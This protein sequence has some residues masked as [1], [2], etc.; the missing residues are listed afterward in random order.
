MLKRRAQ[1]TTAPYPVIGPEE[2]QTPPPIPA[3]IQPVSREEKQFIFQPPLVLRNDD[4]PGV[5]LRLVDASLDTPVAGQ[6]FIGHFRI[7]NL[8]ATYQTPG[9]VTA[10]GFGVFIYRGDALLYRNFGAIDRSFDN[11]KIVIMEWG[12]FHLGPDGRKTNLL[13]VPGAG[14]YRYRVELY[15]GGKHQ[16]LLDAVEDTVVVK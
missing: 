7:R 15:A 4:Q 14:R 10:P 5:V 11:T 16:R 2:S 9:D 6:P 3:A 13:V 8:G 1:P 12:T